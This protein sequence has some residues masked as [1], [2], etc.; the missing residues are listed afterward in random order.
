MKKNN[1]LITKKDYFILI[2]IMTF[3]IFGITI[4][5]GLLLLG[6]FILK[7]LPSITHHQINEQYRFSNNFYN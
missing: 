6:W 5:I 7:K 1:N 3:L 2:L 4:P